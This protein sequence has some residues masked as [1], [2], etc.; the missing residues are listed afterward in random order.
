MLTHHE[1]LNG[2]IFSF[3]PNN[4]KLYCKFSTSYC[5]KMNYIDELSIQPKEL[6]IEI[7]NRN[8]A[9]FLYIQ[10]SDIKFLSRPDNS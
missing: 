2:H 6:R 10:I 4:V 8:P 7:L 3:V 9:S 5:I 1:E